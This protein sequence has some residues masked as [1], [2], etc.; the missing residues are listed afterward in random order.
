PGA[1]R[2]P[3]ILSEFGA[4]RKLGARTLVWGPRPSE[5]VISRSGH[6]NLLHSP[7]SGQVRD[8]AGVSVLPRGP[9]AAR[10]PAPRGASSGGP[11]DPGSRL[12]APLG[13]GLPAHAGGPGA[14]A[15]A[16]LAATGARRR[17][18]GDR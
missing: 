9:G 18:R 1:D 12:G 3:G 17:G 14:L 16:A 2:E 6:G 15:G 11:G 4:P 7:V 8:L 5:R 13:R 10:P